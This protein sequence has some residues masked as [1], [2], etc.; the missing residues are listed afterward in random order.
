MVS[1]LFFITGW[2]KHPCISLLTAIIA[3]II[4]LIAGVILFILTQASQLILYDLS[5]LISTPASNIPLDFAIQ[6]V[7]TPVNLFVSFW[8]DLS[9]LF[10]P[11]MTLYNG[12]YTIVSTLFVDFGNYM[13]EISFPPTTSISD[14]CPRLSDLIL[15]V[16][17]L[18]DSFIDIFN[19]FD[20]FILDISSAIFENTINTIKVI[21]DILK[22]II[23][24]LI[25]A[26]IELVVWILDNLI[27]VDPAIISF[28]DDESIFDMLIAQKKKIIPSII[29]FF[30]NNLV[31]LIDIVWVNFKYFT[32]CYFHDICTLIAGNLPPIGIDF[33][34]FGYH[35]NFS[36]NLSALF[37][38]ACDAFPENCPV[39][40]CTNIFGLNVPCLLATPLQYEINGLTY[41]L[42]CSCHGDS[43]VY[44]DGF[45]LFLDGVYNFN[46]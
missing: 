9:P 28:M 5:T 1:P 6:C 21:L 45:L 20:E 43:I 11:L 30:W 2:F 24:D 13:C 23:L 42:S 4:L 7:E 22:W 31:S 17:T 46:P 37:S 35:V 14:D 41:P 26:F 34:V 29:I 16:S 25:P 15:T 40:T 3:T 38:V 19:F 36:I 44:T 10:P 39:F 27:G 8:N 33:W 18:F 32:D 12:L